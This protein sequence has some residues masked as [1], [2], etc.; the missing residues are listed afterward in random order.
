MESFTLF[1]RSHIR[2]LA[3]TLLFFVVP[4]TTFAASSRPMC[5]LEITT[6]AGTIT[7]DDKE[8]V[9]LVKG[10]TIGI[11][12]DSKN[13]KEAYNDNNDIIDLDGSATS[14]PSKT[15]TYTYTFKNGDKKVE[16]E[17]VVQVVEGDFTE[18]ALT[19]KSLRPTLSGTVLGTKSVQIAIYKEGAEKPLFTSKVIKVKNGKWSTKVTKTLQKRDYTVVL[20]GEK[21][22]ELNTIATS[23]LTIGSV[24]K[25][26]E[27]PTTTFVVE[28]VPLLNGGIARAGS[29][30]P[31]SYL[32]VI[33]IGRAGGKVESISIKQNGSASTNAIVGFMISDSRSNVVTT[34]KA[35]AGKTLFKDKVATVPINTLVGAG[36]MRLFTIKAIIASSISPFIATQLKLDVA[37]VA[38][39]GIRKGTLPIRGTTW[40]L[41]Y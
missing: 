17:V 4:F 9:L 27:S 13:A 16:C 15:T 33:N 18:T 40:T 25:K 12:W 41:G 31:I 19:T 20:L 37:G 34:I 10:E 24:I 22:T 30:V 11:V 8:T 32:Q 14:S 3:L 21:Q 38:T 39:N 23:T 28:S 26:P 2:F 7:T 6:K 35:E 36:Q 5:E 1:F 29:V